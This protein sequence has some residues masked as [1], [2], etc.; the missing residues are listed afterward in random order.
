MLL[1]PQVLLVLI[2]IA[3]AIVP[4][5]ASALSEADILSRGDDG[6][7]TAVE[8]MD[9]GNMNSSRFIGS[10]PLAPH[11]PTLTTQ[12]VIKGAGEGMWM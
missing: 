6:N 10:A 3:E 7:E 5:G 12:L 1:I 9:A 8:A 2:G 4:F 11:Y